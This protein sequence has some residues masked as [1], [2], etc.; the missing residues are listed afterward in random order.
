MIIY[1]ITRADLKQGHG[2]SQEFSSL[3]TILMGDQRHNKRAQAGDQCD[4]VEEQ[5]ACLID[6]AT[7]SN[8]LGRTWAGWEPW[9]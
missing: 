4:S 5:I 3:R 1:C 7:D 8:I 2:R 9:V 6:H